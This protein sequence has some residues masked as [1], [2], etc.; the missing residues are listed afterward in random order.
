MDE[1]IEPVIKAYLSQ[2]SSAMKISEV[3]SQHANSEEIRVDDLIGGLVYRLMVPMSNEEIEDS[4]NHAEQILDNLDETDSDEEQSNQYDLLSET[5][6]NS[7][8]VVRKIKSPLCNCD[9]C[10]KLR[11]CLLNY[12]MHEC[13]DSLSQKFKDA[14][15]STCEKHHISI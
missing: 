4:L 2:I 6:P 9:I 14:I 15:N 7:T 5:Y 11:V 3:L 12:N 10:S 13:S 8:T 1:L